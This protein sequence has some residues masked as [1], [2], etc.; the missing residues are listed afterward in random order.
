[1][2]DHIGI[3]VADFARARAFY[4]A[5]LAPLGMACVM[6]VSAEETGDVPHAGFGVGNKPVFWIGPCDGPISGV[7]VALAAPDHATVDAFHRAALAAG[8]RDNGAPGLRAHYHPSYYGAFV[9]CP[10]GHNI[11]AVCHL[12][13]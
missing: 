3:K 4:T 1:M 2:L 5:A 12:P 11:E 13:V 9:L 10:D 8:G 6:E 7:H